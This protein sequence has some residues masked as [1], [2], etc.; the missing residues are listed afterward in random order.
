MFRNIKF[1]LLSILRGALLA[2]GSLALFAMPANA[3]F[4]DKPVKI[5]V[6]WGAG[7]AT[8][9]VTRALQDAFA[10]ELGT[11]IV[12]KNVSGAAGTIGTAEVASSRPDGYTVLITPAGPLTTQPHLRKIPYDLDSF[13]PIGRIMMSPMLMMTAPNSKL[14]SVEEYLSISDIFILPSETESFGLV[15][16]E[17]MAS[18]VAVISTNSGGLN[19]VNI[20][21]ITG[22][23]SD[24]GDVIK[25][26]NDVLSIISDDYVLNEFKDRAFEHA[27]KFNLPRILPKYEQLYKELLK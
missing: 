14:K 3:G 25:M 11:D 8:D 19:E 12:V 1:R 13:D 7:G 16:L 6:A 26:S 2:L 17:A 20:D 24:V 27:K 10:R 22:Y 15:A 18:R 4:P 9:T 21:G 23:L 5:V